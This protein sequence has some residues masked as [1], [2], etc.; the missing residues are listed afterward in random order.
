MPGGDRPARAARPPDPDPGLQRGARGSRQ[1]CEAGG[2]AGGGR[3]RD[4]RH[5]RPP[6]G[7][8]RP[9]GRARADRRRCEADERPARPRR[10]DRP[11]GRARRR[12]I[13]GEGRLRPTARRLRPRRRRLRVGAGAAPAAGSSSPPA[14]R[15]STSSSGSTPTGWRRGSSDGDVLTLVEKAQAAVE[16]DEQA[17]MEAR[18]RAGEFTFDDF[19][20]AQK[21]L[22]KMGSPSRHG[23]VHRDRRRAHPRP[24]SPVADHL[25]R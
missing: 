6:P 8:R 3:R 21:M 17:E 23:E 12:G 13:P 5:R 22:K 20:A 18:M 7:R 15:S 10:N 16:A 24:G 11:G 14:A 1:G 25:D 9:D 4:R 2:R 19:L